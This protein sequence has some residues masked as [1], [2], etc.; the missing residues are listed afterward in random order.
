MNELFRCNTCRREKKAV[1]LESV[2]EQRKVSVMLMME[3]MDQYLQF[4]YEAAALILYCKR[5]NEYSTV[6]IDDF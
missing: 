5:C 3:A 1:T 2:P 6:V 4:N